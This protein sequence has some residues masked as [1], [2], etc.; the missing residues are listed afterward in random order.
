MEPGAALYVPRGHLHEVTVVGNDECLS[1]NFSVDPI[2]WTDDIVAA[3][4]EIS[5]DE[6]VLREC[7][8]A[9]DADLVTR[10][11]TAIERAR[12]ILSAI[13]AAQLVARV[14]HRLVS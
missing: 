8:N 1:F 10:A 7:P 3:L 12:G 9:L 11:E 5:L 2:T 14:R 13:D 6:E 4:R